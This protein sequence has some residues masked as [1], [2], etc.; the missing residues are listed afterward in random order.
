MS[1]DDFIEA[2]GEALHHPVRLDDVFGNAFEKERVRVNVE[3]F[4]H[5][6]RCISRRI[7][8][9][10]HQCMRALLAKTHDHGN[11]LQVALEDFG[12]ILDWFGPIGR[13]ENTP[14]NDTILDHIRDILRQPC[15]YLFFA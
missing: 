3:V 12:A 4:A 15:V 8:A 1:W 7:S 11:E 10:T 14:A 5:S 2:F 9:L 6:I 13:P